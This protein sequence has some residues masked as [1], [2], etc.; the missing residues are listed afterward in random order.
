MKTNPPT[1]PPAPRIVTTLTIDAPINPASFAEFST[2]L[3][4]LLAHRQ[5]E[6]S[7]TFVL[8]RDYPAGVRL[9]FRGTAVAISAPQ[10]DVRSRGEARL[11]RVAFEGRWPFVSVVERVEE[12]GVN[13]EG[14][15]ADDESSG[16]CVRL[17]RKPA[18]TPTLV[19]QGRWVDAPTPAVAGIN[20]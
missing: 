13:A 12:S 3:G 17:R 20:A 19:H 18:P 9:T 14:S 11:L 16:F 2:K 10:H 5:E 6:V 4:L 8:A 15:D 7:P 1:S